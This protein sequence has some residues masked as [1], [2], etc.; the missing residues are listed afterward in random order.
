MKTIQQKLPVNQ[1]LDYRKDL[2]TVRQLLFKQPLTKQDKD[3][4]ERTYFRL[5]MIGEEQHTS[6]EWS[7]IEL[8][9]KIV[10]YI[11]TVY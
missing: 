10:N 3:A 7:D 8:A 6:A 9:L 4:L 1:G 2:E 11:M 5:Q